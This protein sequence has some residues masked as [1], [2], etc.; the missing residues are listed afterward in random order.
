VGATIEYPND[1]WDATL[2][3]KRIG[4]GFQPSLGFVPR[5]GV[6]IFRLSATYQPRPAR[7]IGPLH[8]RQIFNEFMPTLV[9]DLSG[10]W[11]SYRIFWAP[12]NWRLES[13]DRFELNIVPQGERLTVPFEIS[14]GV[15]IPAG[16]YSFAR[17]R[18][19]G[20]LA[21][22]R[23]FSGQYTWWF[24]RFYD[25]VLDQIQLTSTWKP[26]PLVIV[27]LSG[28]TD[29]ARIPEGDFTKRLI[30]MR[31]RVNASSNL[32]FNSYV[33]YDSDSRLLGSNTRLRWTFSPL[34]DLF[35]V[36]NHNLS[37]APLTDPRAARWSF[38][39]NQLLAK[40]QYAFRY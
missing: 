33:Q 4:D 19:E 9:T 12:V 20:G 23:P 14:D 27:E 21:A 40:V 13:G 8:V 26:S 5:T 37:E 36:Y 3:Y 1:L 18:V 39:S 16:S 7:P 38:A 30:G 22:K 35:V 31:V 34:G 6:Q 10:R 11:E 2:S 24:G 32:Q 25:G 29:L 15:T 28:E 17:F